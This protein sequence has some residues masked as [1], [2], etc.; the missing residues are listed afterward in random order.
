MVGKRIRKA[1]LMSPLKMAIYSIWT[2]T[3]RGNFFKCVIVSMSWNKGNNRNNM[4]DATI[5]IKKTHVKHLNYKLY[6]QQLHL[7]YWCNLARY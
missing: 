2:E 1:L 6:Y 7:K 5:Q 3:C 4:H